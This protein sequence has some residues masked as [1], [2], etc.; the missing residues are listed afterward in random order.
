MRVSIPVAW[1]VFSTACAVAASAQVSATLVAN[2][3]FVAT[4]TM[5]ANTGSLTYPAGPLVADGSMLLPAPFGNVRM[6]WIV[7]Q[8][9]AA[10]CEFFAARTVGSSL[11][12]SSAADLT[13]AVTG[14]VG[15]PG[16]VKIVLDVWDDIPSASSVTIDIGNDGSVEATSQTAQW[17]YRREWRIPATLGAT[18]LDVRIVHSDTASALVPGADWRVKV[19]FEPSSHAATDLGSSCASNDVGWALPNGGTSI[20][21]EHHPYFLHAAPG[22]GGELCRLLARGHG[23]IAAFVVATDP[24]RVAPGWL[25]IGLG[26]DDLLQNVALTLPGLSFAAE[27][28]ELAVPALPP[29]L[30]FWFQHVSFGPA[31]T[32]SSGSPVL[33]TGV[34]NLVRIDT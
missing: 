1:F 13:M 21:A 10:S 29:G 18:G 22:S 31:W 9:G 15:L 3:P 12:Y 26:C 25:G 6:Q 8:P 20:V 4:W 32:T 28:W 30:T 17:L 14:P 33:R 27:T 23:P 2:A 7:P 11:T 5:G 16:H 24:T 19:T 34:S